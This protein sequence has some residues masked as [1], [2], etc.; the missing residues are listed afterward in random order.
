MIYYY[1]SFVGFR[2]LCFFLNPGVFYRHGEWRAVSNL[3]KGFRVRGRGD[4][5]ENE[6]IRFLG[7]ECLKGI[8]CIYE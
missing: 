4:G 5:E 3:V 2:P 7:G 8:R 6:C 1:C